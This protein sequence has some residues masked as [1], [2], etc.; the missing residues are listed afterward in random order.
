M[1][2]KICLLLFL[3]VFATTLSGQRSPVYGPRKKVDLDALKTGDYAPGVVY[4]KLKPGFDSLL[5]SKRNRS[6]AGSDL[7]IGKL[8]AVS[9]KFKAKNI[10]ASFNRILKDNKKALLH[11]AWALSRWLTVKLPEN[12]NLKEAIKA[13][14]TLTDI[15]EVAEPSYNRQLFDTDPPTLSWFPSDSAFNNQWHFNHTAQQGPTSPPGID[16]DI[17]LPEAWDIET[18]KPSVIVAVFDGGIDTAHPDLRQNLWIGEDGT[19]FGINWYDPG[20]PLVADNHGTHVAGTIGAVNNNGIGVSG[21]A[22]GNGSASSGARIMNMQ[23]FSG[24]FYAGD[25]ATANAFVYAADNGASIAQNSWGGANFSNILADAIDYFIMNGGGTVLN[26]G[27]VFFSVGNDGNEVELFP[28]NYPPVICVAATGYSDQKAGY[29]NYGSWVDI[30]APGGNGDASNYKLDILSTLVNGAYGWKNGTSMAC[31]HVSGVAALC[32]SKAQGLLSNDQLRNILVSTTDNIYPQNPG[33]IG[34]LG[35]GR[36]NAYNAL[37]ATLA[38]SGPSINPVKTF[39]ASQDCG[40][41]TLNWTKNDLG[42]SVMIARSDSLVFG[43]ASGTLQAGDTIPGG[44]IIIYKGSGTSFATT[45]PI[46]Q[47][48]YYR[49]WSYSGTQYSFHK[50]ENAL[51]NNF[52]GDLSLSNS[53]GCNIE[54]SWADDLTCPKDSVLL[55]ANK[56]SSFTIPSGIIQAG[57]SLPSGEKVIYKGKASSFTYTTDLDSSIYIKKW[58]FNNSHEYV[59]PFDNN[60]NFV[61]KPNAINT[62]SATGTGSSQITI[63]WLPASVDNCF[64]GNSYL[65]AYSESGEF[66]EPTGTYSQGSPITGG[67]IVLYAG[68]NTSFNHVGLAE[69]K[70]Y[71]YKIWK[72]KNQSVYS[73]GKT[74]CGKT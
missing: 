23:L 7:G 5:E 52:V 61:S 51:Y 47:R 69:N 1:N 59:D 68:A 40:T 22:G 12:I 39:T 19:R 42:N 24:G 49:I 64:G 72:V 9:K 10:E 63:S 13:Y 25:A 15:I 33:Y 44:G 67:G 43:T 60:S 54:T 37:Q 55:V 41:V 46:K 53:D 27:I 66:G 58:N 26:G 50:T 4:L 32:V 29:S 65:L 36:V 3:L 74:F 16:A 14:N 35:S 70:E 31:P 38:V 57:E 20:H 73:F 71:C 30:S 56:L 62:V 6:K 48:R 34:K 8:D 21:I 45:I 2:T 17:D 18:G 28:C 11:Q